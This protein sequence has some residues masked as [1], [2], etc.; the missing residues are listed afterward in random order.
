MVRAAGVEPTTFGFGGRDSIQ[1]SYARVYGTGSALASRPGA[2]AF[3]V[4]HCCFYYD[5]YSAA[6]QVLIRRQHVP[7]FYPDLP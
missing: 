2:A 7:I 1:L 4:R 3:P 5:V 6:R